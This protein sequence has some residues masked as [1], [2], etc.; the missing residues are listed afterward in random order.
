MAKTLI[1]NVVNG[2]NSFISVPTDATNAEAFATDFLDGMWAI[3]DL[4]MTTAGTSTFAQGLLD[5]MNIVFKNTTTGKKSY[6]TFLIEKTKT[7]EAVFAA[8]MGLTLNDVLIDEVYSLRRKTAI[9][10]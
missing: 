8:L 10:Y 9:K 3:Q 4:K 1:Q 2:K 5:E 7:D 6:A